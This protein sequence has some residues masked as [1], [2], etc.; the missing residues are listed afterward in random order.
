MQSLPY[1]LDTAPAF[2]GT[3][4]EAADRQ[5]DVVIVGAG[6]TGLSAALEFVRQGAKTVVLEANDVLGK[7]SGRNGGQCNVGVHQDFAALVKQLGEERASRYYRAFE[8]AVDSVERIVTE[9]K[10]DCGFARCGKLKLATK[11][12]HFDS[13]QRTYEQLRLVDPNVELV[14]KEKI[15]EE[16]RS[17]TFHGGLLQST[18]ASLHVGQ[19]GIGLANAV[20][21]AGG[22][23]LDKALVTDV[24]RIGSGRYSVASKRGDVECSDVVMATGGAPIGRAFGW[25]KRRI[26]SVGSFVIVS[27]RLD[28][29]LVDQLLPKRR[30]YVTTRNIGH[31][32]RVTPDQRLLFGGRAKFTKSNARSD[33]KSGRLLKKAMTKIF[34]KFNDKKIDYCWGGQV[35]MTRDRFPRCGMTED[36]IHYSMGYSGHG[37]Q[38]SVQMGYLMA[39]RISGMDVENPWQDLDWPA[40]PGHFGNAW[41]LPAVGAYY[42]AMDALR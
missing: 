27:E 12:R 30:C 40:I 26:V 4:L 35:D 15:S 1:W 16:V 18:S 33:P 42:R 23:V 20:V 8:A 5:V 6:L 19:F 34:P 17:D 31:Y 3:A 29:A 32:F 38:M 37:V 28:E 10:I 2:G 36:G 21:Q 9:E 14:P 22:K 24:K 11:A 7:A 13:L 41:F 25:F 39:Q